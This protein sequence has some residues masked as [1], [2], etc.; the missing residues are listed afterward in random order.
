M[1]YDK[2]NTPGGAGRPLM[3]TLNATN[4]AS[5]TPLTPR[6]AAPT[7]ASASISPTLRRG[8]HN[9]AGGTPRGN[10]KEEISTPVKAF[11]N[12]NITPRSSSRKAR[13]DSSPGTPNGTPSGTPS[14]SKPALSV[15]P[16]RPADEFP[17]GGLG[18]SLLALEGKTVSRPSSVV[19][20]GKQSSLSLPP[21]LQSDKGQNSGRTNR[22]IGDRE[23]PPRFFYANEVRNPAVAIRHSPPKSAGNSKMSTFFYASSISNTPASPSPETGSQ[24]KFF[25]ANGISEPQTGRRALHMHSAPPIGPPLMPGHVLSTPLQQK[26]P[27]L[28][29]LH[30]TLQTSEKHRPP[31]PTKEATSV[32][33]LRTPPATHL[34]FTSTLGLSHAHLG[35]STLGEPPLAVS[36]QRPVPESQ[37]RRASHGK[38]ASVGSLDSTSWI[39]MNSR[40]EITSPSFP[41]GK[42]SP[43]T[44]IAEEIPNIL[45]AKH[46]TV[47]SSEWSVSL[48]KVTTTV[49]QVPIKNTPSYNASQQMDLA[50]NAR[51][52]RKVLDLEISNSSLLAINRT[53][54]REMRKQCAEL[55]RYRRLSR[56]GRLSLTSISTGP[57]LGGLPNVTEFENTSE[58]SDMAEEDEESLSD[59]SFEDGALSPDAVVASDARHR[60]KD[61]RRLQLDLSK[62]QQLLVDSQKLNQSLKKCLGWTEELISEGRKALEYRVRVSDIQL[63]GRVLIPDDIEDPPQ[64]NG[65]HE[66]KESQSIEVA[67]DSTTP[68]D[69]ERDDRDSGVDLEQGSGVHHTSEL[70]ERDLQ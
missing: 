20:E 10:Q 37:P 47:P 45:P 46:E 14:S 8:V 12:S 16:F 51:R 35:H 21:G 67:G 28:A 13:V 56:S 29:S 58:L 40:T 30:P 65:L 5:K 4:M 22:D 61:E 6:I 68:A 2:Q 62:H 44:S 50:A 36:S 54:E 48:P 52:E 64:D 23:P 53:L 49:P 43:A 31:S 26:S 66:P 1:P 18:P 32:A 34:Q 55:R 42:Q 3:P 60:E 38:S 25:R 69:C 19:S 39:Q 33:S 59:D 17:A 41:V 70:E 63:G 27:R 7:A 15:E 11:L 57:P 24:A 9:D